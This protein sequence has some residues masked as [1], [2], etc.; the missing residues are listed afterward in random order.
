MKSD[1]GGRRRRSWLFTVT[2]IVAVVLVA[3]AV[4]AVVVHNRH[5]DAASPTAFHASTTPPASTTT[6]PVPTTTT[7]P[8]TTAPDY[9]P[10]MTSAVNA[11]D[12]LGIKGVTMG[13]AIEDRQTGKV[14]AGQLGATP[15]Y[16]ASVIK[17]FTVTYLLHEQEIGALK[18]SATMQNNITRALEL[19]DDNAMDAFWGAY[20]GVKLIPEF[21]QLYGLQNTTAPTIL[22]EWGETRFSAQDVLKVYDYVF[23]KLSPVD[24]ALIV[25]DLGN[26][27]N[28]GADGFDQAFGLLQPPRASTVK[29][30]QG[31]MQ[32]G[33]NSMTLNTT[34]VLG[35]N[36][37]FLI[38]ILSRQP[39]STSYATGR[40]YMD[41]AA[42]VLEKALAPGVS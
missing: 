25:G 24:S 19:S 31:W 28:K 33:G 1:T 9:S 4:V 41:E 42:Q 23:D 27:A 2:P 18:L 12:G 22:G 11:V 17:L 37:Q 40:G 20:G 34:G 36:N 39:I 7:P 16:S 15:F 30:K 5:D 32:I 29:A 10:L 13:V 21:V 3:V 38:A 35:S 14:V 6:S 8:P 26:A